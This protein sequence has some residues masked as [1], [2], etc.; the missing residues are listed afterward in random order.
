[1][2]IKQRGISLLEILLV[3]VIG[4]AII[5]A[6]VRYFVVADRGVKVTHAIDQIK[7]ISKASYQWLNE[8]KQQN[9]QYS[10]GAGTQ[11][12]M[13]A[14]TGAGLLSPKAFAHNP[15]GGEITIAPG[16]NPSYIQITFNNLPADACKNLEQ[17]LSGTAHSTSSSCGSAGNSNTYTGTF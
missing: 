10:D 9:F 11:I 13:S 17:R 2:T 15:W 1:M 7:S 5:V 4:S 6:A 14:L 8:Q 3:L 16:T 12:T